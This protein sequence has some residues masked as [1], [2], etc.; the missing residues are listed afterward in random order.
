[1]L[2][3]DQ[4]AIP[5]RREGRFWSQAASPPPPP[6]QSV[7]MDVSESPPAPTQGI[8]MELGPILRRHTCTTEVLSTQLRM[9]TPTMS[10]DGQGELWRKCVRTAGRVRRISRPCSAELLSSGSLTIRSRRMHYAHQFVSLA[11]ESLPS[12]G[13]S[14]RNAKILLRLGKT[15]H[16]LC[17]GCDLPETV[18]RAESEIIGLL[19]QGPRP[20][21][22]KQHTDAK[23]TQ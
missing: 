23:K 8:L 13:Q 14:R 1:M 7:R 2:Q 19:V 20:V 5:L 17:Q 16:R 15:W 18:S 6:P 22:A 9:N 21:K 3:D 10:R 12:Q 4:C 11:L